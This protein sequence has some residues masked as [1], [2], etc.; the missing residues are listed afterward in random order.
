MVPLPPVPVPPVAVPLLLVPV[1]A[2]DE[3]PPPGFTYPL[4]VGGSLEQPTA[5]Y[6]NESPIA[7]ALAQTFIRSSLLGSKCPEHER[8][9]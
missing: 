2:V 8:N 1:P 9:F 3:V 7:E 6:A 5:K 4:S